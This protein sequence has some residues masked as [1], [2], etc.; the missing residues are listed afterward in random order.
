MVDYEFYTNVYLGTLIPQKAFGGMA[1]RAKEALEHFRNVYRVVSDGP[2]TE[3]LAV[4]A[5]AESIYTAK[6]RRSGV[7]AASVGNVSVRYESSASANRA[8]WRELYEKA[9]IY[10]DIYRGAYV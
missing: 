10:L 7:S 6:Q 5:M 9:A 4:C 1:A 2:E 3:K 8:L